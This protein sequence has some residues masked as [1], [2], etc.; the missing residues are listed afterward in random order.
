MAGFFT[1]CM[2]RTLLDHHV[3]FQFKALQVIEHCVDSKK[4][5]LYYLWGNLASS[6]LLQVQRILQTY[7]FRDM[8]NLES[9]ASGF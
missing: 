1:Q 6:E 8:R 4:L 3:L 9:S 2:A 7:S 5:M